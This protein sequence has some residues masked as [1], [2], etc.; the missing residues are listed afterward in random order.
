MATFHT[1]HLESIE[2]PENYV[3]DG[4]TKSITLLISAVVGYTQL[5]CSENRIKFKDTIIFQVSYFF[6]NIQ[7]VINVYSQI[8]F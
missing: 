7:L 8:Y 1:K 6:L 5:T 4:T 3:I 2:E